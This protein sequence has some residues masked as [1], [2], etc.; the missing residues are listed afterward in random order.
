MKALSD[1]PYGLFREAFSRNLARFSPR[2]ALPQARS[3]HPIRLKPETLTRSPQSKL[4]ETLASTE[5]P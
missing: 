2:L 5:A 1:V 4:F 3:L